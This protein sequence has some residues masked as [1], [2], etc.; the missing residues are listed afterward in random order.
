MMTERGHVVDE[1]TSASAAVDPL[2]STYRVTRTE[3]FVLTPPSRLSDLLGSWDRLTSEVVRRSLELRAAWTTISG[4]RDGKWF[5]EFFGEFS[6]R[7]QFGSCPWIQGRS[8]NGVRL[9][10]RK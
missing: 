6:T 1:V 5:D 7:A 10:A 2:V 8:L 4:P 9:T 3:L